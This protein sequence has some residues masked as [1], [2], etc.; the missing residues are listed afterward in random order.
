M[1]RRIQISISGEALN[2]IDEKAEAAK[3][4][5]SRYIAQTCVNKP[6]VIIKGAEQVSELLGKL[7][8]AIAKKS[9][10]NTFM[11][12]AVDEI[13]DI[14]SNIMTAVEEINDSGIE[15]TND[16]VSEAESDDA[17][18]SD[19]NECIILNEES[20]NNDEAAK[21]LTDTIT[22]EADEELIWE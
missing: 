5:R 14:F 20:D 13:S 17:L 8:A 6:P 22:I 2:V 15:I 7:Y 11:L 4:S 18:G 3:M 19:E 10:D 12:K 9:C 1:N 16:D 21:R